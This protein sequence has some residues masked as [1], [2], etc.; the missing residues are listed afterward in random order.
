MRVITNGD[1]QG[2][3]FFSTSSYRF[4]PDVP[5]LRAAAAKA[6]KVQA[7]SPF[8]KLDSHPDLYF[9]GIHGVEALYAVMG[10][11]CESVSRKSGAAAD[12]TTGKW[13]DGRVGVYHG[14]VAKSE[15]LPVLRVWGEKG[16]TDSTGAGGYDGLVRAIEQQALA[17]Y[18]IYLGTAFQLTD[19]LLDFTSDSEKLG[20]PV[21]SDL[22]EGKLTLPIIRLLDSHPEFAPI[23]RAAM[24]EGPGETVEAQKVLALLGEYGELERARRDAYHYADRARASLSL[25]PDNQYRSALEEITQFIVERDR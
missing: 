10:R 12:V 4:H 24:E 8:N 3:P 23:V 15:K 18:G 6:T 1:R 5:K 7:S 20:K 17:D 22:R 2:T 13:K 19:D 11:G 25:L 14:T 21:L 16:T 9:Y